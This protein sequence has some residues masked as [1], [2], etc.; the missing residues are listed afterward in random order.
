MWL[1]SAMKRA[2]R[3]PVWAVPRCCPCLAWTSGH[4]DEGKSHTPHPILYGC[5]RELGLLPVGGTPEPAARARRPHPTAF[6]VVPVTWAP[7]DIVTADPDVAETVP[8]PMTRLP[9]HAPA[10][11][12]RN[13]LPASR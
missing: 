3:S 9:D 7:L 12:R 10:R 1:G 2:S 11:L 6:R 5:F 4:D 13:H 8:V